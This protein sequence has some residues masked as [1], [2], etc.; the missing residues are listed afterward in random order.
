MSG[1]SILEIL[2]GPLNLSFGVILALAGGYSLYF[3]VK[4]AARRNHPRAAML[5]RVGGWFYIAVG[6][7]IVVFE[8]F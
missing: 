7:A 8:A 4:D 5:A 3:N 1:S 2:S 6:A